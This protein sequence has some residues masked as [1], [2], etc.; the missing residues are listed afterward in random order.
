MLT[1]IL[2]NK[3]FVI[4]I[5][6]LL[7]LVLYLYF[8]KKSCGSDRLEGNRLEGMRNVDLTTLAHDMVEKPW[9]DS[10]EDDL[11]DKYKKV[12]NEFDL[13]A[14]KLVDKLADKKAKKS[15]KLK[16]TDEVYLDYMEFNSYD[17]ATKKNQKVHMLPINDNTIPSNGNYNGCPPCNCKKTDSDTEESD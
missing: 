16:R 13:E 10:K 7:L 15:K 5:I 14:D 6:I 3:Y 8:Q 1:D 11:T 12:N 17:N 9:T 2:T 4:A